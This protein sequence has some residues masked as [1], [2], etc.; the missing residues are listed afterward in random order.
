MYYRLVQDD[1]GNYE[2]GGERYILSE[3]A[4]AYTPQGINEGYTHFDSREDAVKAW[5]LHIVVDQDR[6]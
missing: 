5:G 6:D 1:N 2:Q 3:C 4:A